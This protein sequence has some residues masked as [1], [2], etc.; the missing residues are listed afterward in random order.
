[1]SLPLRTLLAL[2]DPACEPEYRQYIATRHGD[3]K[4]YEPLIRRIRAITSAPLGVPGLVNMREELDPNIVAEYLDYQL[5]HDDRM[6]FEAHCLSSDLFLAELA[7]VHS[8]LNNVLGTPANTTPQCRA[9]VYELA[10]DASAFT[11]SF[12]HL[13]GSG[14]LPDSSISEFGHAHKTIV[15]FNRY[16]IPKQPAGVFKQDSASVFKQD[17]AAVS[18]KVSDSVP[19]QAADISRQA[20]N[21]PNKKSRVSEGLNEWRRKRYFKIGYVLVLVFVS[22]CGFYCVK[23]PDQIS[24]FSHFYESYLSKLKNQTHPELAEAP[25]FDESITNATV[26]SQTLP[27]IIENHL[28]QNAKPSAANS[29]LDV[30]VPS[31]FEELSYATLNAPSDV[32]NETEPNESYYAAP[33]DSTVPDPTGYALPVRYNG[34]NNR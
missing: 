21:V 29:V 20:V 32:F 18:K 5:E 17:S 23:Y 4:E 2:A 13:S 8:I 7:S 24:K 22:I 25:V 6:K 14:E 27:T 19:N 31:E 12:D 9:K 34:E 10:S 15:D 33:V 30:I 28:G 11:G 1:M 16:N 26:Y 3:L